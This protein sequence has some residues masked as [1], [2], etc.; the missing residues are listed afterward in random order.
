ML[1][2]VACLAPEQQGPRPRALAGG[3]T[4][5]DVGMLGRPH[6]PQLECG[7]GWPAFR[8]SRAGTETQPWQHQGGWQS[9][10]LLSSQELRGE[11]G[12]GRAP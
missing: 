3:W 1:P 9:R 6:S 10:A 11:Q 8:V 2:D 12:P 7:K 5:L 4:G